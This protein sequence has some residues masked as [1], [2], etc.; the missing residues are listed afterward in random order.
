[1][2]WLLVLSLLL[3]G[4]DD[5]SPG[6]AGLDASRPDA[7]ARDAGDSAPDAGSDAGS[8]AGLDAGSDAGFDSGAGL[9]AGSDAG[10]PVQSGDCDS[11]GDCPGADCVELTPGGYRVCSTPVMDAT[12]CTG[13][14]GITLDQCCDT[15]EC[16]PGSRCVNSSGVPFCGGAF[17]E[18]RNLCYADQCGAD[19][20]CG[21]GRLCLPAEVFGFPY[22]RC[23]SAGCRADA[24]CSDSPGGQC[25][26]VQNPCCGIPIGLGCAYPDTCRDSSDCPSGW[27]DIGP[28]GN[29]FC[30]S[31]S[32]ECPL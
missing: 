16:A 27:C 29:T 1:M 22:R 19:S 23:T 3:F 21:T 25:V 9:D 28:D 17:M 8:D 6:D 12:S 31:R 30:Q 14:G 32:M 5:S 13:G 26:P 7:G 2:R 20:E 4:C 10:E 18:P 15:G 24:D 11:A